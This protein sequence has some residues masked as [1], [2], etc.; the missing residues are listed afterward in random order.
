MKNKER[1]EGDKE[2]IKIQQAD[3]RKHGSGK[4]QPMN[5]QIRQP[6]QKK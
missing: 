6:M 5:E 4:I 2:L 3:Q 1:D